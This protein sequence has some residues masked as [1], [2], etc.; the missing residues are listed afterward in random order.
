MTE[1]FYYLRKTPFEGLEVASAAAAELAQWGALKGQVLKMLTG[2]SCSMNT[3]DFSGILFSSINFQ[4][5]GIF[6]YPAM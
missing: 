5:E 1:Y 2:T 6:S 4:R 3:G